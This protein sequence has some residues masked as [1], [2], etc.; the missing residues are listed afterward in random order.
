M[1]LYSAKSNQPIQKL[2]RKLITK[3]ESK[4]GSFGMRFK[5]IYT[6]YCRMDDEDGGRMYLV[7]NM[8]ELIHTI[9]WQPF[10]VE[11]KQISWRNSQYDDLTVIL[12]KTIN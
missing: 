3:G 2:D 6:L 7:D 1:D 4:V 11:N 12:S 10:T 8:I 9:T 5:Q